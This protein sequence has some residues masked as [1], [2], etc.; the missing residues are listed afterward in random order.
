[1]TAEHTVRFFES[2][3]FAA[4]HADAG[5]RPRI[6]RST[7]GAGQPSVGRHASVVIFVH[8]ARQI[9]VIDVTHVVT[10]R[11]IYAAD[12]NA[13]TETDPDTGNEPETE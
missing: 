5:E 4:V 8:P 12:L 13:Y 1:V 2:R 10:F 11:T 6:A 3:P 9:E 7:P